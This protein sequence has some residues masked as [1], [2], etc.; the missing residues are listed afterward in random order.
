MSMPT[1]AEGID[2][3]KALL[4]WLWYI[5]EYTIYTII[6]I[7]IIS[8]FIGIAMICIYDIDL[9]KQIHLKNLRKFKT[10]RLRYQ[11]KRIVNE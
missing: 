2:C 1:L 11:E 7:G 10:S 6:I 4:E 3:G 9:E 5:G 8:L